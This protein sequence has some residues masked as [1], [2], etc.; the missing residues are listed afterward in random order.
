MGI[1]GVCINTFQ[2]KG[3][4]TFFDKSVLLDW[5]SKWTGQLDYM[6]SILCKLG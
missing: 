4:M 1:T 6:V 2:L 3:G 5:F